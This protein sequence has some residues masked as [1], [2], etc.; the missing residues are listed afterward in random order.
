MKKIYS[1]ELKSVWNDKEQY[2]N[3]AAAN[4]NAKINT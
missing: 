1:T 3:T 4:I 2:E